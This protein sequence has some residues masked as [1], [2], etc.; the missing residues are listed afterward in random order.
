MGSQAS[1][2]PCKVCGYNGPGYYQPETHSCPGNKNWKPAMTKLLSE[3]LGQLL[4]RY[5]DT[6]ND[7]ETRA[8]GMFL[9]KSLM[10]EN[11]ATIIE[12][13]RAKEGE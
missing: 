11:R 9:A 5:A 10:W 3:R 8:T 2:S 13:L 1:A 7:V 12:A 4:E 6:G